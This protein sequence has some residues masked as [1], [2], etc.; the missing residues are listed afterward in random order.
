MEPE[1]TISGGMQPAATVSGDKGAKLKVD[2]YIEDWR[3]CHV[4]PNWMLCNKYICCWGPI[5]KT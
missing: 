1:T 5:V 2:S 3:P 4:K